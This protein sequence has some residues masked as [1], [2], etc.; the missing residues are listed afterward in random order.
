MECRSAQVDAQ[1]AVPVR[2]EPLD[3]VDLRNA[4]VGDQAGASSISSS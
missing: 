4:K 1:I 3:L 2:I